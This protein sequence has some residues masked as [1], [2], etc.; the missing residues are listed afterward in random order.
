[1]LHGQ[2]FCSENGPPGRARQLF[3]RYRKLIQPLNVVTRNVCVWLSFGIKSRSLLLLR[4]LRKTVHPR[5]K[6]RMENCMRNS[7][8]S[9][10]ALA[11]LLAIA[12]ATTFGQTGHGYDLASLDK[13]TA[14]CTDFYQY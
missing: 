8:K 5:R 11:L 7:H 4:L 10:V 3:A 14:A 2:L 12:V 13:N 1:M 6:L 9:F